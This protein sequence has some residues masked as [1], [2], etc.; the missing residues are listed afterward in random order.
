MI[1]C[2]LSG[3]SGEEKEY[4]EQAK[5]WRSAGDRERKTK[6]I[7]KAACMLLHTA[8]TDILCHWNY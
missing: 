6:Y 8:H 4:N 2:A 3:T 1:H 7:L 5:Y